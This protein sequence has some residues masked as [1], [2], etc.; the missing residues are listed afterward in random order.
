MSKKQ[1]NIQTVTYYA[2]THNNSLEDD[3]NWYGEIS[4]K[5]TEI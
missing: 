5:L 2:V 1:E 3:T 4:I